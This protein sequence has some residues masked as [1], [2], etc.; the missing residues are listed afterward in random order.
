MNPVRRWNLFLRAVF[1]AV[2]ILVLGL[3]AFRAGVIED[4]HLALWPTSGL[5]H[6]EEFQGPQ[7]LSRL[8][9]VSAVQVTIWTL[10]AFLLF[11]GFDAI[12][13]GSRRS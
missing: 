7:P 11:Y 10:L 1:V 9:L 12:R 2:G 8:A 6:L 5:L 3:G 13:H 4:Q